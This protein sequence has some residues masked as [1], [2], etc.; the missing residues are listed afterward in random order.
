MKEK[1]VE[2][3]RKKKVVLGQIK[4]QQYYV[5]VTWD[6]VD[7][8]EEGFICGPF[9]YEC[10]LLRNKENVTVDRGMSASRCLRQAGFVEY[11]THWG[12]RSHIVA[13]TES[14]WAVSKTTIWQPDIISPTPEAL[15]AAAHRAHS[16][17]L[18]SS[19]SHHSGGGYSTAWL[20]S[21]EAARRL[22]RFTA[23]PK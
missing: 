18:R 19:Y 17:A 2:K 1:V 22:R 6:P 16:V 8:P 11:C 7:G 14:G 21:V 12:F 20:L 23:K 13:T 3:M 9:K 15:A 4:D 5:A 10:S